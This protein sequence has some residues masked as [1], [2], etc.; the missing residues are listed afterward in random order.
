MKTSD[1]KIQSA[2]S[3][4]YEWWF[5]CLLILAV[6]A[7]AM[8][9]DP[10]FSVTGWN[11]SLSDAVENIKKGSLTRQIALITLGVFAIVSLYRKSD[12]RIRKNGVLGY[13]VIFLLLLSVLSV[14]VSDDYMLTAKRVIVLL[15]LSLGALAIAKQ[16]T[17]QGIITLALCAGI[18]SLTS[19]FLCELV[20]GTFNPFEGEY[21]FTGVMDPNFQAANCSMLL[22]AAIASTR[23]AKRTR[24]RLFYLA[25]V[26]ISIVFLILTKSRAGIVGSTVGLIVYGWLVSRRKTALCLLAIIYLTGAV[27]LIAGDEVD[28]FAKRMSSLGRS[29]LGDVGQNL[30][31]LTGR[32]N[33]WETE[34]F[35]NVTGHLLLGHGYDSFWSA[36]HVAGL[37]K[38][39]LGS[40]HNGYLNILLGLGL[41]GLS[42]YVLIRILGLIGYFSLLRNSGNADYAFAFALLISLSLIMLT[43]DIQLAPQLSSFIDMTLLARIAL[44]TRQPPN[45]EFRLRA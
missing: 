10:W 32:T 19:G 20:L 27:Y 16:M 43:L 39:D 33:V 41:T 38:Y 3:I 44:V 24:S 8:P 5:S 45:T 15:M 31:T 30:T 42:T 17:F 4:D 11:I 18:F 21:R 7:A 26:V 37:G 40:S 6:F 29:D 12:N 22:I 9:F 2:S 14:I 13:L 25:L 28:H 23:M 35:P 36:S 34:V 1:I